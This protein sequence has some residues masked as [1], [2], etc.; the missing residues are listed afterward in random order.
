MREPHIG[1][2]LLQTSYVQQILEQMRLVQDIAA[3]DQIEGVLRNWYTCRIGLCF[4][5]E[6]V[7]QTID[8]IETST[9]CF[10]GPFM[11]HMDDS[12]AHSPDLLVVISGIFTLWISME[13][14]DLSSPP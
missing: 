4:W 7:S 13:L 2:H 5:G 1:K 3:D 6:M 14:I 11:S 10:D 9:A 8:I 12:F